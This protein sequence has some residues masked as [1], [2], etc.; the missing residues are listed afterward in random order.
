MSP[1]Y[2]NSISSAQ[3]SRRQALRFLGLT[4]AAAALAPLLRLEGRGANDPVSLAGAEPG[5]YRFHIGNI[6]AV[7]LKDGGI[8]GPLSKM[9]WW[10]DVSEKDMVST[11]QSAFLSPNELGL[12]FSVLLLHVGNEL[13]LI[14]SGCGPL[15]GPLG[16][17]LVSSLAAVGIKPEQITAVVLSHAH[18]D[19][20]GGLLDAQKSPTFK[21][22]QLFIH[23]TEYDFWT[24]AQPD[25]SAVRMP[26]EAKKEAAH[27]AQT[28]L[29]TLK[30]RW[31]KVRGGQKLF[32]ALE[33]VDAPGHTPGHS[34]VLISS[35]GESLLHVADAIHHHA[36]SFEHPDWKFIA[37]VQPG[38]ALQTRR[39]LLERAV[40]ERLRLFGAHL[41]FP[42]LGH[43]KKSDGHFEYVIEPWAVT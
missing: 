22:A 43:V 32:G 23:E 13:V 9:T 30:D 38:V 18:G 31:Q 25:M 35:E 39:R 29:E 4:G 41:P 42:A 16:G 3:L 1:E 5:Y 8:F 14:D 34:A 36:V 24:Q 7:A 12:A 20:F 40:T 28:Y 27:N 11:L 6:E 10:A 37:D 19:H 15:F 21:N 17:Q 33:I 26:D 2:L